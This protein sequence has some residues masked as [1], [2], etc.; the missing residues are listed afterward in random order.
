[1]KVFK[2]CSLNY[3]RIDLN[4]LKGKL[5]GRGRKTTTG[6][7]VKPFNSAIL[8]GT[9]RPLRSRLLRSRSLRGGEAPAFSLREKGAGG[10]LVDHLESKRGL[11]G[12]K[13][14]LI[15]IGDNLAY[16][17]WGQLGLFL[18]GTRKGSGK[19][20]SIPYSLCST[21]SGPPIN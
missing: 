4:K 2:T 16:S 13:R 17:Y 3:N 8:D 20:R 19:K 9:G 18:L 1:M 5:Q 15:P 11:E 14:R 7:G 6:I 21:P 10:S 12:V